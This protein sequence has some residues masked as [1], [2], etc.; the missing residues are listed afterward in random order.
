MIELNNIDLNFK[1]IEDIDLNTNNILKIIKNRISILKNIR[2]SYFIKENNKGLLFGLDALNYQSS[3]LEYEYNSLL[4]MYKLIT[5]KLYCHY[6]KL[7]KIIT[8]YINNLNEF[9]EYNEEYLIYINNKA[10]EY[11]IY[12][13]LELFQEYEF[14]IIH[15]IHYHI[16]DVI[17]NLINFVDKKGNLLKNDELL[18]NNGINIDIF[19]NVIKFDVLIVN[20][21]IEFYKKYLNIFNCYHN[22]YYSRLNIR[23]L[24]LLG[25]INS[26]INFEDLN[27]Y[28]MQDEP[29][30]SFNVF[31]NELSKIQNI[32]LPDKLEEEFENVKRNIT[33]N[34]NIINIDHFNQ[35]E[36]NDKEINL[37]NNELENI[38]ISK[39]LNEEQERI[40]E[41]KMELYNNGNDIGDLTTE[42][43]KN[44]WNNIINDINI[45]RDHSNISKIINE[46]ESDSYIENSINLIENDK[47]EIDKWREIITNKEISQD[48]KNKLKAK[49]KRK[50]RKNK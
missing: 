49:L 17:N 41:N 10:K 11:P 38:H 40:E 33:N 30:I 28:Y 42:E 3:L 21:N 8:N 2:K 9:K 16:Y 18:V 29:N 48:E 39:H 23:L 47:D 44:K 7:L 26:N 4:N 24:I 34:I 27:K 19:V 13:D 31:N 25:Q 32:T 15:A 46:Q 45:E 35:S 6:Y 14:K 36:Q 22:Q 5:N 50:K 20:Q 43:L 12:K 37:E 1:Q